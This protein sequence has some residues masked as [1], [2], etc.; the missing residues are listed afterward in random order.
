MTYQDWMEYIWQAT[1]PAER[2]RR[3]EEMEKAIHEQ[4]AGFEWNGYHITDP[5]MDETGRFKVGPDYY[6]K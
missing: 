1:T 5:T 4:Q 3:R 2:E 6:R